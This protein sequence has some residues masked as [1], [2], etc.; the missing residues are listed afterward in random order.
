MQYPSQAMA[1]FQPGMLPTGQPQQQQVAAG[2]AS[3]PHMAM[4][5]QQQHGS[6]QQIRQAGMQQ[7]GYTPGSGSGMYGQQVSMQ[8]QSSL[9]A[10]AYPSSTADQGSRPMS[11]PGMPWGPSQPAAASQRSQIKSPSGQFLGPQMIRPAT[12][13]NPMMAH[14]MAGNQMA[15]HHMAGHHMMTGQMAGSQVT[16]GRMAGNHLVGK[17]MAGNTASMP[18]SPSAQ[19]SAYLQSAAGPSSNAMSLAAAHSQGAP[20]PSNSAS[21]RPN[22]G[23]SRPGSASSQEAI[24]GAE[25]SHGALMAPGRAG[26]GQAAPQAAVRYQSGQMQQTGYGPSAYGTS[27]GAAPQAGTNRYPASSQS[28]MMHGEPQL[29]ALPAAYTC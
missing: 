8:Q 17:Q 19:Q 29:L 15:G 28:G 13:T 2:M 6:Q 24:T 16:G 20:Q 14:Q 11:P 7:P 1:A 22:S 12:A 23:S 25:Q 18:K 26:G 4:Q 21:S 5:Q 3:Q 9:Q 27:W 10:Q